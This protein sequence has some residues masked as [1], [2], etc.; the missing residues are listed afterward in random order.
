M[1]LPD[2]DSHKSGLLLG[3]T[4]IVVELPTAFPYFAAIAAIVGSGV[5]PAGQVLALALFNFCFVVPLV[6]ILV[7]LLIAGQQAQNALTTGRE[8]LQ[9][10]WPVVAAV[11]LLLGGLL[12]VLLG[13]TGFAAGGRGKLA[14]PSASCAAPCTRE[15]TE[16]V[17]DDTPSRTT[18]LT[19]RLASQR[20]QCWCFRAP[21]AICMSRH[22]PGAAFCSGGR[23]PPGQVPADSLDEIWVI[24]PI[25]PR[26]LSDASSSSPS[27]Y[28]PPAIA[29]SWS[30]GFTAAPPPPSS[31]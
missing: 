2:P 20:A 6:V 26:E 12:A 15:P 4:I 25:V 17:D 8:F 5:D 29:S 22:L 3:A 1:D 30:P 10:R 7:T 16:R 19:S 18:S 24:G 9:R 21:S 11:L 13:A 28:A 27:S 31:A 14:P 23:E